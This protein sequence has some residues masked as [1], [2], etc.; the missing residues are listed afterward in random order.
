MFKVTNS[1]S[2]VMTI[3]IDH[4]KQRCQGD[5]AIHFMHSMA[6]CILWSVIMIDFFSMQIGKIADIFPKNHLKNVHC[7]KICICFWLGVVIK[8]I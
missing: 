5:G 3:I 6:P 4:K 1:D 7:A 2:N 8:L